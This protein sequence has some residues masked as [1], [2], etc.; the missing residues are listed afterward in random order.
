MYGGMRMTTIAKASRRPWMSPT[1]IGPG[2]SRSARSASTSAS[3]PI[4]RE[5][6]TRTVSPSRSRGR[7]ASSAAAASATGRT[8]PGSSPASR[9][10]S[11]R[12]AAPEPD[13]DDQVRDAARLFA[14]RVVAVVV[15]VAEL[16]HLAEDGDLSP[17]QVAQQV[18]RGEHRARR[19]VV[20][21]VDDGHGAETDQRDPMRRGPTAG[22]PGDDGVGR[23][24]GG[25]ARRRRRQR[26]VD[27][28]STESRDAPRSGGR[29]RSA[30][31]TA[32]RRGRAPGRLPRRHRRRRRSRT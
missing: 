23:Q 1:V 28:Q 29:R 9:A 22:E 25:M 3:S 32:S 27:G 31:R 7:S 30:G 11:A 5:A 10:P 18:E 20:A 6:L 15:L 4:P 26:V 17:G 12:P 13:D 8:R 19:G 16:E 21:V 2:A 14:H 24:P